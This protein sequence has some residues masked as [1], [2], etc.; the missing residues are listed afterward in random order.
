MQMLITILHLMEQLN[1]GRLI[2][3]Y[4]WKLYGRQGRLCGHD[5]HPDGQRQGEDHR[6]RQQE[7]RRR[8]GLPRLRGPRRARRRLESADQRRGAAGLS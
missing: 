4:N 7:E 5:P 2:N 8:T 3:G 6:Q 1:L